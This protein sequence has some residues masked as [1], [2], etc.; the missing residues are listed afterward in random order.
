MPRAK[1]VMADTI[2]EL[3]ELVDVSM[4]QHSDPHEHPEPANEPPPSE[5]AKE[6]DDPDED[7]QPDEP[8]EDEPDEDEPDED[9]PDEDPL[10]A[11]PPNL[12][13]RYE[14]R[15]VIVDA[16]QYPGSLTGKPDFV[17]ANWIAWGEYDD[18][19]KAPAGPALRVPTQGLQAEKMARKGDYIVRQTVTL[20]HSLPPDTQVDVW[21]QK[22]F[23][24][25]FIP[26]RKPI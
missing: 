8:D 25:L 21:P 19:T 15:I 13:A 14:S 18:I 23:E 17:D 7:D 1:V 5:P 26:A 24:K 12:V 20:A 2:Q 3:A 4:H 11:D 9:E 6:L 10:H 22:D 16:W